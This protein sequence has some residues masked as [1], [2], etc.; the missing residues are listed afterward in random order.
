MGLMQV[1][2]Y[3]P[4]SYKISKRSIEIVVIKSIRNLFSFVF[5]QFYILNNSYLIFNFYSFINDEKT[6]TQSLYLLNQFPLV[7]FL[8]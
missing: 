1:S 5:Q 7:Y 2:G 6:K 3:Q 8:F 4:T